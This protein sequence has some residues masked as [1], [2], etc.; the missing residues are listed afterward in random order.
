MH[1]DML[2]NFSHTAQFDDV[3]VESAWVAGA[4]SALQAVFIW[5]QGWGNTFSS[6]AC[7]DFDATAESRGSHVGQIHDLKKKLSGIPAEKGSENSKGN[8]SNQV[9]AKRL[10][11]DIERL[12]EANDANSI[13]R[14]WECDDDPDRSGWREVPHISGS[15]GRLV[16]S[17]L[18][19]IW[20]QNANCTP[21]EADA[22][23]KQAQVLNDR[24]T[25]ERKKVES[26]EMKR[27]REI[28][29]TEEQ[30]RDENSIKDQDRNK[31]GKYDSTRKIQRHIAITKR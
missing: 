25:D 8:Y 11:K 16:C 15:E 7:E 4:S 29:K 18:Q 5:C 28:L 30:S 26:E 12:E 22:C 13:A 21:E 2:A 9:Y 14:V 31:R 17:A 6:Y 20:L 24:I 27:Y 23:F 19:A 3:L 1:S 10:Q